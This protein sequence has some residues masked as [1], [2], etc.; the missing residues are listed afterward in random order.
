IQQIRREH[1]ITSRAIAEEAGVEFRTEY[2]LEIGGAVERDD[3]LKI[4]HALSV[5]TG[6]QCTAETV[7]GLCIVTT[8]VIKE[9]DGAVRKALE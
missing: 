8:P 1:N 2:L 9:R 5:L 7:G 4:L 6:E 3:A